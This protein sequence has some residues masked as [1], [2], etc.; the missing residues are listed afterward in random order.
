MEKRF[1]IIARVKGVQYITK[2]SADTACMAEHMALD[3]GICGKHEY[4]CDACMAYDEKAMK[5][6][7]FIGAALCAEPV[8][9]NELMQKIEQNNSRIKAKDAAEE[10]Y[11]IQQK[12]VDEIKKQLDEAEKALIAARMA[13]AAA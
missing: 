2:V 12:R 10:E 11:N 7:T 8:S 1:Y 3:A 6:D 13:F 9:L 5:T 4:G